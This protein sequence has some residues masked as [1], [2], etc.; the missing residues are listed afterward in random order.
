MNRNDF[1]KLTSVRLKDTRALLKSG[2]YNGA[3]Y[4]CGYSIECGLKAC[5]AK[6]TNRYDFP[7]LN[8]VKESYTHDLVKLIKTAGLSMKLDAEMKGDKS[9][10]INWSVVKDWSE[11]SRYEKRSADDAKDLYSAVADKKHG[12]LQWIKRYW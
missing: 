2:N 11:K 7:N 9:F 6:Q 10:G 1:K 3:Y 4:L 5:I 8:V 12:V